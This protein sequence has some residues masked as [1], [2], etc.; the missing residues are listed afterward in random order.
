MVGRTDACVYPAAG[1]AALP[2]LG[3]P[4]APSVAA[5]QALQ[6]D[7]VIANA[8]EHRPADI[9]ALQAAGVPVWVTS[10]TTARDALNLL[11]AIVRLFDAPQAGHSLA[12]LERSYEITRQVA[13]D[14]PRVRVF[15]HLGREPDTAAGPAVRWLVG[16]RATYLH[17][18]LHLCG[19]ANVFA[20]RAS[21]FPR[22]TSAEVVTAAPEVILLPGAPFSF[23]EAD[24]AAFD[25]WPHLPAVQAGRVYWVD[26]PTLTWPGTHLARALAELPAILHIPPV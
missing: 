26:G 2:S 11:W 25:A 18:V 9:E 8:E 16:N 23:T 24:L 13:D 21:R 5:L 10:P 17:D 22:V 20:D 6:P 15:C 4:E 1:V 3:G 7:L 12:A 14:A 19:G